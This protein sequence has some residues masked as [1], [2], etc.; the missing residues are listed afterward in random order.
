M[1]GNSISFP[2]PL[3]LSFYPKQ[4]SREGL[5]GAMKIAPL[6][7]GFDVTALP[8]DRLKLRRWK[9]RRE[10]IPCEGQCGSIL[11]FVLCSL[12]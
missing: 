2:P 6:F 8:L 10:E 5:S 12:D 1:P 4:V 7:W 9:V 3:L 11:A